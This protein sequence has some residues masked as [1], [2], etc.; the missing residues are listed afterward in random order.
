M[1]LPILSPLTHYKMYN[2]HGILF[3]F[4]HMIHIITWK[5]LQLPFALTTMPFLQKVKDYF[6]ALVFHEMY[7]IGKPFTAYQIFNSI[8]TY[9]IFQYN[10]HFWNVVLWISSEYG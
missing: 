7:Q 2:L 9:L 4:K 10:Y 5:P 8:H 3:Y 1:F 6:E